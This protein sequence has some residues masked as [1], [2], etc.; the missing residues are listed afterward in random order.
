MKHK[1]M[2]V[3]VLVILLSVWLYPKKE[4]VLYLNQSA[5]PYHVFEVRVVCGEYDTVKT[6]VQEITLKE[7]FEDA[8]PVLPECPI[9]TLNLNQV[10]TSH[11]TIHLTQPENEEEILT[12]ININQ[13]SFQTL[14]TVPGIT[15]TRAASII[16]YREQHGDF[17][18]LD[19]L[20][21]VKYIGVAT[22]EKIKPYLT[23]S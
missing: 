17:L 10:L 3:V 14:I 19:E 12:K 20:I 22:L 2:M 4:E 18:D 8:F 7:V 9:G 23:I 16:I 13:A 21:H 5:T 11:Q 15:E 1:I 6:Y